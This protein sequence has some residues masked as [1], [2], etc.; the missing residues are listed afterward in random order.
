MEI[1]LASNNGHKHDE[2]TRLFPGRTVRMPADLG[3]TFSF[4]ED[5]STFL[6]NA[7]GK[8]EAL[9]ALAGIPVIA[10]DS[11]LC[12]DALGGEPGL[13]SARYGSRGGAVLSAAQ[14]NAYLLERM[15]G[16]EDRAAHFVCCLV[17][18]LGQDRLFV[19]QETIHG[20]VALAPRGDHGFGYD[21]LFIVTER[22]LTIAELPEEEKDLLSHR[23]R[24]ARRIQRMLD[25]ER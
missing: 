18:V 19:A 5:G 25:G 11:G 1:L 8:A 23:G 7:L 13:Y 9:F 16:M 20:R 2:F 10:D 4:E 14:R 12:V 17:L 15:E 21:P 3:L 24:A 6:A 22:G